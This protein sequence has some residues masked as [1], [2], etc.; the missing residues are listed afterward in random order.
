M[1]KQDLLILTVLM[2]SLSSYA[3]DKTQLN[4]DFYVFTSVKS[5]SF[6]NEELSV[7]VSEL[8]ENPGKGNVEGRRGNAKRAQRP[9]EGSS[10]GC[11]KG[12]RGGSSDS[13]GKGTSARTGL[14]GNNS[15]PSNRSNARLNISL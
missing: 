13:F 1:I 10:G 8:V 7:I 5:Q 11:K 3:R 14:Q 15:R 2:I 9:G 6:T 4:T 12:P